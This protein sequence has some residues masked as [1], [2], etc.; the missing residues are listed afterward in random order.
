MLVGINQNGQSMTDTTHSGS[1]YERTIALALNRPARIKQKDIAR[2]CGV[3]EA[4]LSDFLNR[5]KVNPN[6]HTVQCVHDYLVGQI[7]A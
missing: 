7:V 6:I 5:K 4:W 1:L 3:T 2:E